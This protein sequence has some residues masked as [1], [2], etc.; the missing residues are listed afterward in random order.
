MRAYVKLFIIGLVGSFGVGALTARANF[1]VS[2]ALNIH[3][4]ADF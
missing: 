1:E 2:A 4:T 3:A